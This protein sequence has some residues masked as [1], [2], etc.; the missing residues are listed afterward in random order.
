M[1]D[2]SREAVIAKYTDKS[3][4]KPEYIF[5][6]VYVDEERIA[7]TLKSKDE[8]EIFEK[9]FKTAKRFSEKFGYE[10]FMLPQKEGNIIYIEKHSNP[11]I[12]TEGMFID[13]KNPSGSKASIKTRFHESIHQADGVLISVEKDISVSQVKKWIEEKL[14]LMNKHDG[15]I[16]AIEVGIK[17]NRKY[18]VFKIKGKELS[19]GSFPEKPR[20]SSPLN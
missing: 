9:E 13:I 2:N 20:L 5:G 16:I 14:Q 11:D 3:R 4:Y 6:N 8:K 10:V 19:L 7:E 12:I 1:N 15:F 17:N 18:G